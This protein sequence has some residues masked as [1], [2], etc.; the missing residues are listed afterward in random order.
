MR[1]ALFVIAAMLLHQSGIRPAHAD[2][3]LQSANPTPHGTQPVPP[4]NISRTPINLRPQSDPVPI[5]QGFGH[6]VPLSFAVRQ[7]VPPSLHVA[8]AN[9]VNPS[10]LVNW[11]GGQPWNVVLVHAVRPFGYR[12]WVSSTTVHI[13]R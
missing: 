5:A 13:Y 3:V 2:F 6:D 4:P 9:Q 7:I 10:A 8:Y 12:V 1:T 11:E